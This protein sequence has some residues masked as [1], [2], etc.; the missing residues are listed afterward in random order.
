[1]KSIFARNKYI[2]VLVIAEIIL[3]FTNYKPETFLVGWDN[4]YP[5][6]NFGEN[7]TRGLFSVWQQYRGLGVVDGMAHAALLPHTL[8]VWLLSLV[9][10]LN[11]LRY[12][13]QFSLHFLGGLGTFL[14]L[15]YLL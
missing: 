5:E 10:P 11:T 15:R 2:T 3:F 14:L 7:I 6:L 8:A 9:F 4:V 1:M 13:V 12:I